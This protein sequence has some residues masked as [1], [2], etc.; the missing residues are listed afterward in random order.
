MNINSARIGCRRLRVLAQLATKISRAMTNGKLELRSGF[1]KWLYFVLAGATAL[2]LFANILTIGRQPAWEDEIFGVSTGW[3]IARS[4]AP[5]P[6][7]LSQY[8]HTGSAV[9]FYGPVSFEAAA[10]LIRL[11]GLSPLVWRLACFGGVFLTIFV[12]WRLVKLGGGD[13]WGGLFTVLTVALASSVSA[14]LPGRWDAVT[15]GLFMGGLSIFLCGYESTGKVIFW[16]A[17]AAGLPI[18]FALG[19][20]PRALTLSAAALSAMIMTGLCFSR[21][22]R[23]FLLGSVLVFSA[24][25]LVH[26][27]ILMPWGQTSVSWYLHVRRATKTDYI[28][29]TPITG[30][31]FWR[32]DLKH[33]RILGLLLI[34]LILIRVLGAMMPKSQEGFRKTPLKVFLTTFAAINL[35]LMTLLLAN[36]LG[37]GPFWLPPALVAA[38]CSIDEPFRRNRLRV[39]GVASFASVCLLLL[40]L[41]EVEQV[42]ATL[43]T[44]DQRSTVALTAL[45]SETIP[46]GAVFYGPVGGYFY[47]VER[48]QHEYLYATEQTTPGL[49]SAGPTSIG[50]NLDEMICSRRAFAIWPVDDPS[51]HPLQQRVPE[52]LRERMQ[53]SPTEFRQPPLATWR[54]EALSLIGQIDGKFG[55]P[56]AVIYPLKSQRCG[57]D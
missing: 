25:L 44:W 56:D 11:F 30:Q 2:V 21:V 13:T 51:Y 18:G 43:L 16:R 26:S 6:S 32:F 36:P 57:K 23:F 42:A 49:A 19:S 48:S 15:V 9:L 17:I 33:H 50:E 46:S 28:N 14:S 20:S 12:C 22:R 4:Q 39:I 40:C 35:L 37:Q 38:M 31:G 54:R 24:A 45:L 52:A 29:A 5:A 27:L 3:S 7:V 47:A 10:W 34:L 8:P 41:E 1:D 55:F 53:G